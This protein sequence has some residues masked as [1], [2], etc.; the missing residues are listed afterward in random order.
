ML[1]ITPEFSLVSGLLAVIAAELPE[2]TMGFDDALTGGM[3]A[4]R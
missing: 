4:L 1:T 2:P 3:C